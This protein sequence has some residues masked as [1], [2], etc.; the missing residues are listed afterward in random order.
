MVLKLKKITVSGEI[1]GRQSGNYLKFGGIFK[2]Q[3]NGQTT[4]SSK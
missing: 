1:A 2:Q 3:K 4:K